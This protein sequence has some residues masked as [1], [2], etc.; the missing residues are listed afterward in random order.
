MPSRLAAEL[1]Q[2]WAIPVAPEAG[3]VR[4]SATGNW[5]HPL[6][7]FPGALLDRDGYVVFATET[8]YRRSAGLKTGPKG[9]VGVRHGIRNLPGYVRSDHGHDAT[10]APDRRQ[11]TSS[12]PTTPLYAE[13]RS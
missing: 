13:G 5:Y 4:Y 10:D 2:R 9:D 8:A 1:V 11:A 6:T 3:T 7:R 12:L